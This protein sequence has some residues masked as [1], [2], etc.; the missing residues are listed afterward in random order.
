MTDLPRRHQRVSGATAVR[1]G[2]LPQRRP[3]G[4]IAKILAVT[5]AVIAVSATSVAAF[6]VW[7]VT[8]SVKPSIHLA[9]PVPGG[10]AESIPSVAAIEGGVNLLVTG[11]DSRTGL[12][13]IYD[14]RAEQDASSGA[15]NND[16]TMLLHIAQNHK[17]AVVLSFP[18]DL[19][20]SIPSC[21]T[22]D[23]KGTIGGSS[24]AQF[25]TALSRAGVPCVALTVQKLTG[26]TIPYAAEINFAGV[27]A[28]STAVGGVAVCLATPVKDKYTNPALDLPAG[29][30]TLVG[31]QALSFLRSRH[32]VGDGSDLGRISN[33]QVF[34]SALA[35]KVVS[36]GVLANPLQLYGLAKAAANN[37]KLSDTLDPTTMVQ[38]GL[39]LRDTGLENV[40]FVQ[41]P[42]MTDPN[43]I[44]RVVPDR[45]AA[46]ALNSALV[47][48]LPVTLTGST[49]RA[50][51]NPTAPTTP[52]PTAPPAVPAVPS[53]PAAPVS[54][55]APA[56]PAAAAPVALPPSITG[57][58]A[59]Q[60]TC[61]KGNN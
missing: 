13:G 19:M 10:K 17:S 14:S 47:N 61:T 28:M 35:R 5:L 29:E 11:T 42:A 1:H 30:S 52:T 24:Y 2:R 32:G 50:A 59:A 9:A 36:G 41:Y 26:V 12:G 7:D 45:S 51:E 56:T 18:R 4:T 55:S 37:M 40:V 53:T 33:Q 54:P 58:T 46:D 15:G 43:D 25:N 31:D 6:A 34:L 60:Q 48:D 38:I 49:G 23:G 44:N 27:S 3:I 16:V 57:Q 39:A 21:P 8:R 20:V 22:P